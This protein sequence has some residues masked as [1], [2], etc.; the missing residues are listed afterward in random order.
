MRD[1]S[2]RRKKAKENRKLLT[3]SILEYSYIEGKDRFVDEP[4]EYDLSQNIENN[5]TQM[6]R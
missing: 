1:E 3:E 2:D 5:E 4:N 6:I